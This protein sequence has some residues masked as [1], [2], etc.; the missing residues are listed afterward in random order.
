MVSTWQEPAV[1]RV[2]ADAAK[3]KGA[4][5][6]FADPGEI[7]EISDHRI[8]CCGYEL[9][10]ALE[11]TFQIQNSVLALKT[12]LL[13][14]DEGY[15]LPDEVILEGIHR[16]YWP[17]RMERILNHPKVYLDGAHNLPA[18]LQLKRTIQKKFTNQR[19]TYIMGVLADKDYDGML[20]E[21]LPLAEHVIMVTPENPRALKAESLAKAATRWHDHVTA[22]SDFCEAAGLA[23]CGG[24]DVILAF[25]SLSYLRDIKSAILKRNEEMS[26]V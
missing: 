22:A 19:I 13:L 21:L 20:R 6:R 18:A 4:G 7:T 14:R 3:E 9:S 1:R 11:G 25:G 2:L 16:A 15:S 12:L 10:P 23:L 5:I 26:H 24:S 17:G 8:C